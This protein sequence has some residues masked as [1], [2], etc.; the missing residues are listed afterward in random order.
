MELRKYINS[1]SA[2]DR[3]LFEAETGTTINYL[4]SAMS[5]GKNIGAE[6]AIAIDRFSGGKVMC[7]EIR[8]DVD[9]AYLRG[10]ATVNPNSSPISQNE[11]QVA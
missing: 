7:E 8:P 2:D 4:R 6:I 11:Q 3:A 5:A 10:T 9:F 1:L